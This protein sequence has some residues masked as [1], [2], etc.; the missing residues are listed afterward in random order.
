MDMA[1]MTELDLTDLS[2]LTV[3]DLSLLLHHPLQPHQLS[4]SLTIQWR[5]PSQYHAVACGYEDWYDAGT[6]EIYMERVTL[7]RQWRSRPQPIDN[8]RPLVFYA[9]ADDLHVESVHVF[10][11][12][13]GI[14]LGFVTTLGTVN[15]VL[16]GR[17]AREVGN[18]LIRLAA[19]D[20]LRCS[21]SR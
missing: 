20:K 4:L 21:R 7:R 12:D 1:T 9:D 11:V 15:V 3:S 14:A 19:P 2:L 8:I 5:I 6:G 16:P 17:L 13:N 10:E 18:G